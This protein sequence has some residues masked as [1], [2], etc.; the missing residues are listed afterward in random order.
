M[1][2]SERW[3]KYEGPERRK[4]RDPVLIAISVLGAVSWILMVPV[5]FLIDRA[6]PQVETFTERLQGI[7]VDPSWDV[8][9]FQ[10]AVM[11]LAVIMLLS[12]TGLVL[13]TFRSK[14]KTDS[15][16]INLVAA[17]GLALVGVA[18]YLGRFAFG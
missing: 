10:Y 7:V 17:F 9:A 8:A 18:Y 2:E 5:V 12:A 3:K 16:R 14:R 6:R 13:S 15:I 4:G 11:L 1:L